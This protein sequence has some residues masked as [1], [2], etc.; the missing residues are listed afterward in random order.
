VSNG[1]VISNSN[2]IADE[3]ARREILDRAALARAVIGGVPSCSRCS[4]LS[5][6]IIDMYVDER[7]E[8]LSKTASD[9]MR[10]FE[11][12]ICS[13]GIDRWLGRISHD[14]IR[15]LDLSFKNA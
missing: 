13:S 3:A 2:A 15:R 9:A 4:L 7:N 11:G 8:G 12:S 14:A 5:N 10:L 6:R 1:A